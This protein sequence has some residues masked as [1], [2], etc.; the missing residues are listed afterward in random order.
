[1]R[2]I[3]HN[4]HEFGDLL[5][6]RSVRRQVD[7]VTHLHE[8]QVKS[9]EELLALFNHLVSGLPFIELLTQG[10]EIRVAERVHPIFDLPNCLLSI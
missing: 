7:R 2:E 1:M 10:C 3:W 9:K 4:K 8:K 6:V 5:L